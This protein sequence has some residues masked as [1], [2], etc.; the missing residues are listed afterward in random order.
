[1]L[2][3]MPLCHTRLIPRQSM[4]NYG[5]KSMFPNFPGTLMVSIPIDSNRF[6]LSP[7]DSRITLIFCC[8]FRLFHESGNISQTWLKMLVHMSAYHTRGNPTQFFSLRTNT[9]KKSCIIKLSQMFPKSRIHLW[10]K[11]VKLLHF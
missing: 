8:S 6:Q 9:V 2:V 11:K 7:G 5:Y 1:M 4:H 3:H 10:S